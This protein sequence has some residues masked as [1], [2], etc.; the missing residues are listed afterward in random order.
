MNRQLRAAAMASVLVLGFAGSAMAEGSQIEI[1]APILPQVLVLY[2]FEAANFPAD[3]AGETALVMEASLTWDFLLG[4]CAPLYPA[5]TIAEAGVELTT[6]QLMVNYNEIARCSYEQFT[7][8]PYW[9]P[10]LVDDVDVCGIV[11]GTDW[12]LPTQAEIEA[13]TEEQFTFMQTT[14]TE[15]AG[16]EFWGGFYFSLTVFVRANDGTLMRASLLPGLTDRVQPI[17]DPMNGYDPKRHLEGGN[18]STTVIRCLR[19]I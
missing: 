15:T 5:I 1:S 18:G 14:L 7:A 3:L 6:E 12:H 17:G 19:V 8:K 16:T 2:P 10:Q 13:L 4:H 11:M 9:I